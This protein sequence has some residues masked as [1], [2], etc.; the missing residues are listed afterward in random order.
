M[1]YVLEVRGASLDEVTS[2]DDIAKDAHYL[3]M[4]VE[5]LR[6]F[7]PNSHAFC[8]VH[9]MDLVTPTERESV[10]HFY[11][12]LLADVIMWEGHVDVSPSSIW[13]E[14]LFVAWSKITSWV[15]PKAK[16]L[17]RVVDQVREVTGAIEVV[18][19][20]RVTFLAILRSTDA[21]QSRS[22]LPD[23]LE[24]LSTLYKQFRLACKRQMTNFAIFSLQTADF[25]AVVQRFTPST[26]VFLVTYSDKC[27]LGGLL[28][29]LDVVRDALRELHPESS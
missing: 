5:Q 23:R 11:R 13:D 24:R 9:K 29:N 12:G 28:C 2:S 21:E 19:F 1:I 16:Y 22:L 15:T 18:L 26:Y 7:S 3:R 4:S 25:A 14:S 27:P 6:F 20:E 10:F 17:Q 8:L